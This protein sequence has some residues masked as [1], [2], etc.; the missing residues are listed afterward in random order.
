MTKHDA[1]IVFRLKD[2][3]SKRITGQMVVNHRDAVLG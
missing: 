3:K 1:F 2:N